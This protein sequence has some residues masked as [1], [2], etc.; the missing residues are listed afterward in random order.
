M[1]PWFVIVATL[2]VQGALLSISFPVGQLLTGVPLLYNDN[3]YHLYQM[4]LGHVFA[5]TDTLIGYDP[6]FAAGYPGGILYNWSAKIPWLLAAGFHGMVDDIVLYKA[7]VFICGVLGPVCVPVAVRRLG[8]GASSMVLGATLAVVLWW[9]SWFHWMFTEGMV[10]F[11]TGSFLSVPY[12][13]ETMR[14]FEGEGGSRRL[15]AL[16]VT[17]SALF[18]FHPLFPLA[19]SVGMLFFLWLQWSYVTWQRLSLVA[20]MVPIL[21]MLPNIPWLIATRR[22]ALG[23]FWMATEAYF[24]IADPSL[25]WKELIGVYHGHIHGSKLYPV[26]MALMATEY[27]L[28]P[29]RTERRRTEVFTL[30]GLALIGLAAVGAAVP[31]FRSLQP[32]RYAPVGY[33]FLVIPAVFGLRVL[34]DAS[35]APTGR[36]RRA[37]SRIILA[38]V[39]CV[40]AYSIYEVFVEVSDLNRG[41]YGQRPPQVRAIPERMKCVTTWLETE[42]TRQGR[43]LF[44]SFPARG[45]A[46][47]V[48]YYGYETNRE[49]IGSPMPEMFFARFVNGRLFGQPIQSMGEERFMTYMD[50]YNIGWIVA[51]S[52]EAKSTLRAFSKV[53]EM[54][55]CEAWT[56]YRVNRPLSFF[57]EGRGVVATSQFN[58]L[59]LNGLEG[60]RVILKYNYLPGL[61]SRP[62]VKI[63]P[64]SPMNGMP[65]FIRI[66]APPRTLRLYLEP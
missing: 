30:V 34:W 3:A 27:L 14:Y 45:Q 46:S 56:A 51:H 35:R 48:A 66:V 63:E 65:P 32:N 52:S 31:V 25:L 42:T 15:V 19:I 1:P 23:E 64:V 4:K 5:D 33:L 61:K 13:V 60:D 7:Y 58:N 21:S 62:T 39:A 49:F 6:T 18:F 53:V 55:G 9:A 47:D 24:N 2:V 59:V 26:I 16:G 17:G 40:G 8:A 57:L 41:H 54:K 36:T 22:Y 12:L 44:E 20:V 29:R 10:S 50:L 28:S 37:G 11:V 38:G 43:V